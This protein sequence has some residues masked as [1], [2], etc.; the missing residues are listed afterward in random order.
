[1]LPRDE[2]QAASH[3]STGTNKP[4]EAVVDQFRAV[5]K[6]H[7]FSRAINGDQ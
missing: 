5:V 3:L 7:D 4:S 6:G 1:L 2:W